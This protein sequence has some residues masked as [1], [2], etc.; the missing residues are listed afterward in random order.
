MEY[1]DS[2]L[3]NEYEK[4]NEAIMKAI[5]TSGEIKNLLSEYKS[6]DMIKDMAVLNLI[7]SLE[8]L[9]DVMF[10]HDAHDSIFDME[11]LDDKECVATRDSGAGN[12]EKSQKYL[13]DGKVLSHNEILFERFCQGKFDESEWMKKCKIKL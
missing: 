5:I 4:L 12:Q 6:K 8:E 3:D 9:S 7:L 13:I 10:S 1:S 11:S 2:S